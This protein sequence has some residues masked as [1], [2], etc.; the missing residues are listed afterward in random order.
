MKKILKAVL[1]MQLEEILREW[2]CVINSGGEGLEASKTTAK[3]ARFL[4]INFFYVF[5]ISSLDTG[6]DHGEPAMSGRANVK[7]RKLFHY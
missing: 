2:L 4:A 1:V 6:M 5:R 7:F 3:K